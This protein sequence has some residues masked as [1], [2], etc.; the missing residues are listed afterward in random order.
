MAV[1]KETSGLAMGRKEHLLIIQ[2]E[3]I[4]NLG[5][6]KAV[7]LSVDLKAKYRLPSQC[8]LA[9]HLGCRGGFPMARK[10]LVLMI[11]VCREED[12]SHTLQ[13][14]GKLDARKGDL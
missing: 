13:I 12:R 3:V 7:Y 2:T 1:S 14:R 4:N 10:Q 5:N 6:N 8:Q 11:S 9:V